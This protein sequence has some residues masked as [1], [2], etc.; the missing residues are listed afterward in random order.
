MGYQLN[1]PHLRAAMERD[2]QSVAR[3]QLPKDV[4]LAR[5]LRDMQACFLTVV[6]EAAVLE[7]A[8][9]KHCFS[10][11]GAAGDEVSRAGQGAD[12]QHVRY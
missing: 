3:G 11:T 4:W 6:R 2:C 9:R 5:C 10:S 8:M 1:K 12:Q 7:A